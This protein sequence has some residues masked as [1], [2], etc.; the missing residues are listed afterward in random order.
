M[1]RPTTTFDDWRPRLLALCDELCRDTRGA[2]L[3]ALDK[4][5]SEIARP[6]GRG[7]GDWTYGLDL[8]AEAGI[9]AWLASVAREEPVSVMTEDA[10]WRHFGPGPSPDE[11]PVELAGF[12]HGG[13]RIAF[14]P[15]DGTR[16][17]MT[18]LR[19]AW[20]VVA[21]APAGDGVPMLSDVTGGI[22]AE[23][24][25]SR[26]RTRRVLS[27]ERGGA[28]SFTTY[29]LESGE[30][31]TAGS[32]STDDDDRA[33]HGYFPFFRYMPDLRP[34][35]SE[36]EAAFFDRLERFEGADVRNCYDDQYVTSAGHLVLLSLG[37]YRMIVDPRAFL[38]ER[39]GRPTITTKPYD[40]AGAVVC[41]EAAGCV[42][43]SPAG[44]PLDFPIDTSTP[45]SYVGY[46]N[47]GT[48]RRLEPHW[49][50]VSGAGGPAR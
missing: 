48:R 49:L 4:G 45:V 27:A 28:C 40:L 26:A 20:T 29:E 2:L 3:T 30:R 31:L 8:P 9:D 32:L 36:L 23:L 34:A 6:Q 16:N 19:P 7:E 13:P 18:D 39:R 50:A 11:E 21:F 5:D 46:V 22:V 35:T 24:P 10:G 14:D 33:D 44:A 25:E 38:A 41:A 42:L 15:V 17:L 12:D 37:T 43:T 1:P 47:A